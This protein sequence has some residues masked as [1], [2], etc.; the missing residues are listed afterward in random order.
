MST[1]HEA[2]EKCA[3]DGMHIAPDT[4]HAIAFCNS[5]ILRDRNNNDPITIRKKLFPGRGF[6]DGFTS[7][8]EMCL[9]IGSD[10]RGAC[11]GRRCHCAATKG[12]YGDKP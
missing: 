10:E 3:G 7:I 5:L 12:P 6:G 9:D 4:S 11:V 1:K 2:K 8:I